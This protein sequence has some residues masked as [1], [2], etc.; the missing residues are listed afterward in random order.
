[1]PQR[2]RKYPQN[3]AKFS[4]AYIVLELGAECNFMVNCVQG[5]HDLGFDPCP[6]STPGLDL[7]Y[8]LQDFLPH[9][10]WG[11]EVGE[12]LAGRPFAHLTASHGNVR[13]WRITN[14]IGTMIRARL[15]SVPSL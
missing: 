6:L 13:L 5:T 2:S 12:Y 9:I 15:D 8:I 14:K 1:M 11:L 4:F 7:S 10:V 3:A